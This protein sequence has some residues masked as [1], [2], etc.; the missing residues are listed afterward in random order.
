[1]LKVSIVFES[2][3]KKATKSEKQILFFVIWETFPLSV[4]AAKQNET[5]VRVSVDEREKRQLF[6]VI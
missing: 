1:M 5:S 2:N 6:A 3:E 4:H